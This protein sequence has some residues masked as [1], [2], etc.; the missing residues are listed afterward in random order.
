MPSKSTVSRLSR[1]E[2]AT[3]QDDA[4]R[5]TIEAAFDA[6]RTLDL[7]VLSSR[8]ADPQHIER[9]AWRL[10]PIL[11]RAH[12]DHAA[13]RWAQSWLAVVLLREALRDSRAHAGVQR[14]HA[15]GVAG[16]RTVGERVGRLVPLEHRY[17]RMQE[18]LLRA[19]AVG[20]GLA[21][22]VF[23][24]VYDEEAPSWPDDETIDRA[25]A[26]V[27]VEHG[28]GWSLPDPNEIEVLIAQAELYDADD[29]DDADDPWPYGGAWTDQGE[30][31]V[32]R[33]EGRMGLGGART[34]LRQAR[35]NAACR[36]ALTGWARSVGIVEDG[37]AFARALEQAWGVLE[38]VRGD[39]ERLAV[40]AGHSAAIMG[41]L[42]RL[43][44]WARTAGL[45]DDRLAGRVCEGAPVP[46]NYAGD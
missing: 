46:S 13:R 37:E 5:A 19:V 4:L 25:I 44:T 35:R 18:A 36:R 1:P 26:R 2:C 21:G 3:E 12:Q 27:L 20:E 29:G 30:E 39:L 38:D 40:A 17:A 31:L 6:G 24:A 11:E 16:G 8:V 7:E 41:S 15:R 33:I 42:D 22:R 32:E 43:L 45:V 23:A 14:M 10:A 34:V 9:S 28:G